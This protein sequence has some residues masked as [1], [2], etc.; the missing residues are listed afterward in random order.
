M[1]SL[2]DQLQ[3]WKKG[4]DD[5]APPAVRGTSTAP[6]SQRGGTFSPGAG[7]KAAPPV[8]S[9]APR[10]QATRQPAKPPPAKTAPAKIMPAEA[11]A[12]EHSPKKLTDAELFQTALLAIDDDVVPSIAGL[13]EPEPPPDDAQLFAHFVGTIRPVDVNLHKPVTAGPTAAESR[14]ERRME[15]ADVEPQAKLDLHGVD[16]VKAMERLQS[17]VSQSSRRGISLLLVIHGKGTGVVEET[18]RKVLD[19]HKAVAEHVSAP[20]RLGG[21][22]ARVVRLK[23]Q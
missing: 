14:L 8:Q 7:S 11:P 9:P 6:Q 23:R 5:V 2:K 16:R 3:D 19:D 10:E 1:K 15:R 17:F 12:L 21:N 13:G 20:A 18:V 4:N 22:G